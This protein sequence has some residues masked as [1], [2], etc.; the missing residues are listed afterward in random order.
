M[1]SISRWWD[2]LGLQL[3][4]RI[5]IQGFLIAILLAAQQWLA[6]QF[7]QEV[8]NAAKAR[9]AT[10]ADGTITGLNTL[11]VTTVEGKSVIEDAAGRSQFIR[12][13]AAAEGVKELR[14]FRGKEIVAAYGEGPDGERAR[15]DIDRAV[16]ADGRTR[17]QVIDGGAASLRAVMPFIAKKDF[18]GTDCLSC[19][20]TQEGAVLGAASVTIDI[21]DDLATARR[22][23]RWIWIGQAA[24]QVILFIVIGWIIGRLLRQLGGEPAYAAGIA[25]RIA[26]GDLTV[27]IDTRPGDAGSLLAAM[28]TM[29]DG[30]VRIVGEV[31]DGTDAISGASEQIAS[32]NMDLSARTEQQASSL[33]ETAASMEE[34]ASTVRHNLDNARMAN[35]LAG[36]AST[37]ALKGGSVIAEVVRTMDTINAS[38][39]QIADIIGVIDSIAFQT[40]ILALNAAVEASRAGEQ[41]RGFAVVASEVRGLAQRSAAAAREIKGLIGDSVQAVDQGCKLVEQAGSTM[42]EIVVSVRR[43]AAIMADVAKDGQAQSLAIAQVNEAVQQMDQV[44]QQNAVL[45]Q[46]AASAAES[47]EQQARHLAELVS[48]FKLET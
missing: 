3:K 13:M 44:T 20:P 32:G 45:V 7:E 43:V 40:N 39:K 21:Q 30:L 8:M 19:H 28:K 37:V 25:R 24:L 12:K 10:V 47:L 26:D 11:M 35:Q 34:V 46:K 5:L 18:R 9:A 2:G 42:D 4:L 6:G 38:S 29:R 16:L 33:E 15:D 22:M 41:G 36:S 17:F 14:V 31:R 1:A 27:A 48:T 23:N